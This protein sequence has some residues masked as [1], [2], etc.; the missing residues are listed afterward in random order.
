MYGGGFKLA[1]R[2][3]DIQAGAPLSE[4]RERVYKIL[5]DEDAPSR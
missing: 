2:P 4:L 3:G 1:P 5:L